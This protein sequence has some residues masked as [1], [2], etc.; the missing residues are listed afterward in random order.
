MIITCDLRKC[1]YNN[2]QKC[3]YEGGIDIVVDN[4]YGEEHGIFCA[5]YITKE[6]KA[7]YEVEAQ[8]R[9]I[10]NLDKYR[11]STKRQ[12][13]SCKEIL[14]ELANDMEYYDRVEKE[15]RE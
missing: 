1:M 13:E 2:N 8:K 3:T 12:I 10:A 11:E 9:F 15:Q 4:Y 5:C 6:S 14:E 7:G